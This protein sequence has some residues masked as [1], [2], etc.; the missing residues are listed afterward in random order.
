MEDIDTSTSWWHYFSWTS[1]GRPANT[2]TWTRKELHNHADNLAYGTRLE[3]VADQLRDGIHVSQWQKAKTRCPHDH[4]YTE[5]NPTSTP[6]STAAWAVTAKSAV[7]DE[8]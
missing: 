5:E 4:E 2:P 3:D 7:V 6:P 8:S 1:A